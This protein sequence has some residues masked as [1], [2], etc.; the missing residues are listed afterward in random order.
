[1]TAVY[2]TYKENNSFRGDPH[3]TKKLTS[4]YFLT[5]LLSLVLILGLVPVTAYAAS[6]INITVQPTDITVTEGEITQQLKVVAKPEN[7]DVATYTMYQWF[8][9]DDTSKA[10][11]IAATDNGANDVMVL[12][13]DLYT[14]GTNTEYYYY[15]C[16]ITVYNANDNTQLAAADSNVVTVTVNPGT[17]Y[18]IFDPCGGTF[19]EIPNPDDNQKVPLTNGKID[20]TKIPGTPLI[21][22]QKFVGWFTTEMDYLDNSGAQITDFE[23]ATFDR[24]TRLYARYVSV[25]HATFDAAGGT[26]ADGTSE[27]QVTFSDNFL[28]EKDIPKEPTKDG[29]E[30]TGWYYKDSEGVERKL[31]KAPGMNSYE[32]Y[33]ESITIYAKWDAISDT[34]IADT[35]DSNNLLL[36][37][38]LMLISAS[39]IYS[40]EKDSH[41]KHLVK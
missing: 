15:F 25:T 4:K 3:M 7:V 28:P 41:K 14:D 39:G 35:D 12:P 10:N 32:F 29:F 13:E 5:L 38:A 2:S 17:K 26:F 23:T 37:S 8:S 20:V 40:I 22:G 19:P 1:M 24:V 11:P 9:C 30:F 34:E 36:W 16:R 21:E 33:G 31:T 6:S 27:Y 18:V